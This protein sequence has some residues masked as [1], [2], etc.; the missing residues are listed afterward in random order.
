MH[1]AQAQYLYLCCSAV[2]RDVNSLLNDV[3]LLGPASPAAEPVNHLPPISTLTSKHSH[4]SF[5]GVAPVAP[6]PVASTLADPIFSSMSLLNESQDSLPSFMQ[7]S[8]V[9]DPTST[10][11]M[12]SGDVTKTVSLLDSLR[13]SPQ[14]NEITTLTSRFSTSSPV[15]HV[16]LIYASPK[17]QVGG[18]F[19]SSPRRHSNVIISNVKSIASPRISQIRHMPS[20][21]NEI[22]KDIATTNGGEP[23][24]P[25]PPTM[26]TISRN[27]GDVSSSAVDKKVLVIKP[28]SP[29]QQLRRQQLVKSEPG[30]GC[31]A[32][33]RVTDVTGSGDSIVQM[34]AHVS[35]SLNFLMFTVVSNFD[36]V[37]VCV[38]LFCVCKQCDKM[39]MRFALQM[40]IQ[41]TRSKYV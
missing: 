35:M 20:V 33:I 9:V 4:L 14:I 6:S 3:S 16:R 38:R 32:D 2:P 41:C 36:N 18:H 30:I 23:V 40:R 29:Q 31:I 24:P 8:N 26:T 28:N 22:T 17:S 12:P 11:T 21:L 15:R 37:P 19:A 27:T 10:S 5:G 13:S 25:S 1:S 39:L 34:Q 7:S